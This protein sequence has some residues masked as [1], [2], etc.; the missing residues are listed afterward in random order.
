MK[1]YE[2]MELENKIFYCGEHDLYVKVIN[3]DGLKVIA[4]R[5][6]DEFTNQSS[7]L[8]E[9][10][11]L[12]DI[13]NMDFVPRNTFSIKDVLRIENE[14]K[15]FKMVNYKD[16]IRVDL[17]C[18]NTPVAYVIGDN[19]ESEDLIEDIYTLSGIVNTRFMEVN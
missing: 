8:D 2:I 7:L 12:N 18:D 3:N 16:T 6:C 19:G 17:V 10:H 9:L 13:L 15:Q 1:I 11:S 4:S 14:G 5:Y